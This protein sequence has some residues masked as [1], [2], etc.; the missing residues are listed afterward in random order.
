M[1]P[2]LIMYWTYLI[3][4]KLLLVPSFQHI[5]NHTQRG[6]YFFLLWNL[7]AERTS[8]GHSRMGCPFHIHPPPPIPLPLGLW[9]VTV[10]AWQEWGWAWQYLW[11]ALPV[12]NTFK[13]GAVEGKV[14]VDVAPRQVK[15]HLDLHE[16]LPHYISTEFLRFW[17]GWRKSRE[18]RWRKRGRKR[19]ISIFNCDRENNVRAFRASR[20][21]HSHV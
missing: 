13:R 14:Q 8:R 20:E 11:Y 18:I 10:L 19:I 9:A 2:E 15:K 17:G 6:E 5:L 12:F 4:Q 21:S 3:F 1:I 16:H 7:A